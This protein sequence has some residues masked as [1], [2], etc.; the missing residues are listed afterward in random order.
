MQV[1]TALTAF[2]VS[3]FLVQLTTS[4]RRR[5]SD[6]AHEKIHPD[7]RGHDPALMRSIRPCA[8]P[9]TPR[10]H[11]PLLPTLIDQPPAGDDWIHAIKHDG[12][13]VQLAI[14]GGVIGAFTRNGH[15]YSRQM[16]PS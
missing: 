11:S 3:A 2:L 7:P 12:W 16:V 9:C 14:N 6:R 4:S 15:D 13:R 1:G 10:I 5:C 8:I